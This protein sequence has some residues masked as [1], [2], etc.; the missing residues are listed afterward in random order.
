MVPFS[1]EEEDVRNSLKGL[2]LD[3]ISASRL[4]LKPLGLRLIPVHERP[5]EKVALGKF[6]KVPVVPLS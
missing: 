5:K 4:K 6:G 1:I 2:V 3:V